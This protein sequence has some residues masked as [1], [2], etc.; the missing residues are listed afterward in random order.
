M[1]GAEGK[2]NVDPL[3]KE[4]ASLKKKGKKRDH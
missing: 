2:E 3:D 4:I 1:E